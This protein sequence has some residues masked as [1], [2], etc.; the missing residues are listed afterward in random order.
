M[1]YSSQYHEIHMILCAF[2]ELVLHQ[3]FTIE[4]TGSSLRRTGKERV[5]VGQ[6]VSPAEERL[7]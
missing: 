3:N 5:V 2:S 1:E 7:T 6:P 4:F